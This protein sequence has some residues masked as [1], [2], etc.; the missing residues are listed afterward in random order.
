MRET[1]IVPAIVR[2]ADEEEAAVAARINAR[3]RAKAQDVLRHAKEQGEELVRMRERLGPRKFAPWWQ[4]HLAIGKTTIYDY[5]KVA[6]GWEAIRSAAERITTLQ[7]ALDQV[8]NAGG[9][10]GEDEGL[11]LDAGE[12]EG[13]ELL[14]DGDD[15]DDDRGAPAAAAPRARDG[16]EDNSEK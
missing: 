4:E 2:P 14:E 6:E 3:E 9:E 10:D 13:L 12:L 7:G 15:E 1:S 5:I 8:S 16:E 11:E